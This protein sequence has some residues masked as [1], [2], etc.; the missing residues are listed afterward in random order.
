M[1]TINKILNDA[2]VKS[3]LVVDDT[4]DLTPRVE[5]IAPEQDQWTTFFDDLTEEIKSKIRTFFPSFDALTAEQLIVSNEFLASLWQNRKLFSP[6]VTSSFFARYESESE[7]EILRLDSIKQKLIEFGLTCHTSGRDFISNAVVQTVELIIMDLYLGSAQRDADIKLSISGLAEIVKRR[8]KN[9]PL[10]ILMSSSPHLHS[11]K[12]EFRDK[13]GLFESAFRVIGKSEI[14]QQNNLQLLLVRLARHYKAS[15]K[16][17]DFLVSWETGI[18]NS[19]VNVIRQIKNLDLVDLA[20]IQQL[21]LNEEGEPTGS[22]LVDIFDKVLQ[23]EVEGE[24]SIIDSAISLNEIDLEDYPAPYVPNSSNLQALVH[25]SL[26]QNVNRLKIVESDNGRVFFGDLLRLTPPKTKHSL[27]QDIGLNDVLLVVTPACDLQRPGKGVKRVMFMVGSLSPF[28]ASEW[29]SWKDDEVR[30]PVIEMP[31]GSMHWIKW[32]PKHIE[33]FSIA[34]LQKMLSKKSQRL[35]IFARLRESHALELQQ[36]LIASMG[37]VGLV[38]PLPAT[39]PVSVEI[40]LPGV[41]GNLFSIPIGSLTDAGGVCY[42]GRANDKDMQ[43]VISESI[44]EDIHAALLKVNPESVHEKSRPAFKYLLG[45]TE[46]TFVGKGINL[47][48]LTNVDFKDIHSVIGATDEVSQKTLII[49]LVKFK[50]ADDSLKLTK[51]NHLKHAGVVIIVNVL[52]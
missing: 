46:F 45:S 31:D 42:V 10:V 52:N 20:Q 7:A 35:E 41:D 49:G 44:C 8:R 37:R 25:K 17:A 29:R 38:A 14:A 22:Y 40:Y 19:K 23:Y 13:S 32:K 34:Q 43:L 16:L 33:T 21:L 4:F 39:F 18:E 51:G 28:T 3:V 5:D 26:F 27:L 1:E 9:P 12:S 6:E 47:P 30:T 48:K 50:Q 15:L 2:N 24:K 36:K 11:K